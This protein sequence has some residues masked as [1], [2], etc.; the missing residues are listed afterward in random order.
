ME[1]GERLRSLLK[2]E[3]GISAVEYAMLLSLIGAGILVGVLAL[4][5][6]VSNNMNQAAQ[7]LQSG[8]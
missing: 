1:I 7:T 8:S 5:G 2:D 4:G 3:N 6:G